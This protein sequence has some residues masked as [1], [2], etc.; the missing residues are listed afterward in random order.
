MSGR[1]HTVDRKI[2]CPECGGGLILAGSSVIAKQWYRLGLWCRHCQ[3]PFVQV[4]Y[5]DQVSL[6][7][8]A[9]ECEWSS[10]Q[11]SAL[12]RDALIENE[13]LGLLNKSK[14]IPQSAGIALSTVTTV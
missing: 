8:A 6:K 5:G 3:E 9:Q 2:L 11:S 4:S 12:R 7:H 14:S 13:R 10:I 1:N